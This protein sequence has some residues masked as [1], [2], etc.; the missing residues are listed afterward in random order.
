MTQMFPG[1]CF[2]GWPDFFILGGL[3]L[4]MVAFGFFLKKQQTSTHQFFLGN[5]SVPGWAACLSFVATEVSAVTI[6]SVPAVAY[7]ENWEYLQFFIGSAVA[8]VLIA[9][10]FIPAFY[11]FNCTTIYEFLKHR[12]GT[13]TQVTGSCFFFITRLLASAVRLMAACLALSVLLG[14]HIVPVIALFSVI[15]IVYIALGGI[16]AVVWT[17]VLQ[18]IIFIG[19]GLA[20]VFFLLG[21]IDGGA[22]TVLRVAGEAGKLHIIDSGP[23]L[24]DSHFWREWF[25]NPNII[26]LAVLNGLF[27]S[28]AAFGT[29]HELMQRLLTVETR[30]ESQKTMLLTIP[31]SLSVLIIYLTI[32]ACLYTYYAGHPTLTPPRK[33]RQNFSALHRPRHAS[34]PPRLPPLGHRPGQHRLP[35]GLSLRLLCD[36]PLQTVPTATGHRPRALDQFSLSFPS[37]P[38]QLGSADVIGSPFPPRLAGGGAPFR[39][40]PGVAGLR[41]QFFREDSV[42]GVQNW[43]HDFRLSAGGFPPGAAHPTEKQPSQCVGDGGERDSHVSSSPPFGEKCR[44]ARMDMAHHYG[45]RPDV[46]RRL[47]VGADAGKDRA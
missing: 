28:L 29:D 32:G 36:G 37:A 21:S 46:R 3:L 41:L 6:I 27:I 9:T 44:S 20:A 24:A 34:P 31:V 45:Y 40:A 26:W 8:R 22:T 10:L 25:S 7:M 33:P 17:N 23:S 35:P 12:F 4:L 30:R 13:L 11:R 43:G 1:P 39:L 18:A 19:G 5:R 14:W 15:S 47:V 38:S 2:V 16:K 42:A